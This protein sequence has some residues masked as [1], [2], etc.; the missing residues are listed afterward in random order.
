MWQLDRW[1]R[2]CACGI[3][4]QGTWSNV[5]RAKLDTRTASTRSHSLRM[6]ALSSVAVWTRRSRCGSSPTIA[7]VVSHPRKRVGSVSKH[8]KD[9]R[10]ERSPLPAAKHARDNDDPVYRGQRHART[11]LHN[12]TTFANTSDCAGLRSQCGPYTRRCLGT[13]RVQGP[14]CAILGPNDGRSS[15]DASRPQELRYVTER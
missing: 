8:S 11:L 10:Y 15:I 7:W 2:A 14:W 3:R 5:W 12:G 4:V 13:L 1:T 6:V 9:T